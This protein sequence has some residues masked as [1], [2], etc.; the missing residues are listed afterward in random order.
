MILPTPE[1]ITR[2]VAE[3]F[4]LPASALFKDTREHG[5]SHPRQ[6][7]MALMERACPGMTLKKIGAYF[8]RDHSTVIHALHVVQ[9]RIATE[10]LQRRL[11]NHFEHQYGLVKSLTPAERDYCVLL[12]AHAF[13]RSLI[14]CQATEEGTPRDGC[15]AEVEHARAMLAH[16]EKRL[17][18]SELNAEAGHQHGRTGESRPSPASEPSS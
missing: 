16:I 12:D 9:D 6:M 10:P 2:D 5:I 17:K 14:E 13:N 18:A 15:E 1:D 8:G 4:G 7:A 11:W 3:K